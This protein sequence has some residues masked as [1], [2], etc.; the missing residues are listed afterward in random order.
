MRR[1]RSCF[2]LGQKLN[3]FAR[4]RKQHRFFEVNYGT[5]SGRQICEKWGKPEGLPTVQIYERQRLVW[6][7]PVPVS[8]F[9]DL[10]GVLDAYE[11]RFAPRQADEEPPRL[12]AN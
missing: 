11:A 4:K 2:G 12:T 6:A 10:V 9:H 3:R 1:C 8:K 7:Q 5:T